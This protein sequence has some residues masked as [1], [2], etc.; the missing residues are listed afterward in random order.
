M[1]PCPRFERCN[2]P[3]C[4]L[5]PNWQ[6]ARYLKG[7][8]VCR[9][10]LE[11][12]KE[13]GEAEISRTLVEQTA[14]LIREVFPRIVSATPAIARSVERASLSPSRRRIGLERLSLKG[15]R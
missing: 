6:K 10:G 4:P 13:G 12:A 7:E 11:L 15:A 1:I 5:D 3:I 14:A 2:A 9:W 8:P